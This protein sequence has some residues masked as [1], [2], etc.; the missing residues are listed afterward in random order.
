ME[1]ILSKNPWLAG[2]FAWNVNNVNVNSSSNGDDPSNTSSSRTTKMKIFFD[3]SGQDRCTTGHFQVYEPYTIPLIRG[4]TK[5]SD[6]SKFLVAMNALVPL[7]YD[8][9][10]KNLPFWKVVVVPDADFPDER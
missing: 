7:N 2:W 6:Y 10:G 9:I 4:K 3:E 1:E 8:L 5:Y